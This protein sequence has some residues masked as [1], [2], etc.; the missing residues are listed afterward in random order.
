[1][2]SNKKL[3][4]NLAKYAVFQSSQSHVPLP[5]LFDKNRFTFAATDNYGNLDKNSLSGRIHAHD[6]AITLFQVQLD[7]HI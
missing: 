6:T 2:Q 1:M 5:N 7:N 4:K 3:R